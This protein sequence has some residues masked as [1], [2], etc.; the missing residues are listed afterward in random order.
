MAPKRRDFPDLL[1]TTLSSYKSWSLCH[2][3]MRLAFPCG[4]GHSCPT[5]E[6][7]KARHRD[8]RSSTGFSQVRQKTLK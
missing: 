5:R 8:S 3:Q 2:Y 7:H 6:L 1:G 4:G